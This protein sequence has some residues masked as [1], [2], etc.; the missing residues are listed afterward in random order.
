MRWIILEDTCISFWKLV[1]RWYLAIHPHNTYGGD[2]KKT[3]ELWGYVLAPP[4]ECECKV[5]KQFAMYIQQ[6]ENLMHKPLSLRQ[7]QQISLTLWYKCSHIWYRERDTCD[8][9]L[10]GGNCKEG[11][12]HSPSQKTSLSYHIRLVPTK[13]MTLTELG[14]C[15][16][17][18][19]FLIWDCIL[20]HGTR[21]YGPWINMMSHTCL[22]QHKDNLESLR[23]DR[24]V[25]TWWFGLVWFTLHKWCESHEHSQDRVEKMAINC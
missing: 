9:Y 11:G 20:W 10:N 19:H 5:V 14:R 12:T 23:K 17:A 25:K 3:I 7:S 21:L 24:K 4:L 15:Q 8:K 6:R 2:N 22:S 18:C 1:S 16:R 13:V